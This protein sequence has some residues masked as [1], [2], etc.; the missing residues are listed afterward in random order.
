MKAQYLA[1]LSELN[2]ARSEIEY[3]KRFIQELANIRSDLSLA[4]AI[5]VRSHI[6]AVDSSVSRKCRIIDRGSNDYI[7][8]GLIALASVSSSYTEGASTNDIVWKS[9]VAGRVIEVRPNSSVI[10]MINDPAFTATVTI[11]PALNRGLD[12]ATEGVVYTDR[13]GNIHVRHVETS[14][15]VLPGDTVFLKASEHTL[16][17]DVI[18]GYVAECSYDPDNAVLWNITVAPALDLSDV[19]D[20]V[21]VCHNTIE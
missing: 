21:V 1:V 12:F 13:S 6:T 19:S 14:S 5:L 4:R 17:V 15:E 3:Q 11:K 7:R 18:I 9:A 16:P 20:V 2:N 10:Q 8:P